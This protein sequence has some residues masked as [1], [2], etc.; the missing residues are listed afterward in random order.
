MGFYDLSAAERIE[1]T[2]G[3]ITQRRT[4]IERWAELETPESAPWNERAAICG[5][6]AEWVR[7]GC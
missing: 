4:V 1:L 2:R 7:I 5:Q 6:V 3:A